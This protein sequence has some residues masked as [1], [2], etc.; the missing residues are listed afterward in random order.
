MHKFLVNRFLHNNI[1]LVL[2]VEFVVALVHAVAFLVPPAK[3][4]LSALLGSLLVSAEGQPSNR[5]NPRFALYRVQHALVEPFV[6]AVVDE[7]LIQ[8]LYDALGLYLDQQ[9]NN[10]QP[11]PNYLFAFDERLGWRL[12]ERQDFYAQKVNSTPKKFCLETEREKIALVG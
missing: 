9:F 8:D 7:T 4:D 5:E 11:I 12:K 1:Q 2:S 10:Q 6:F 3:G